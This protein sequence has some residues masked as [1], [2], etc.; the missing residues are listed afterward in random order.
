MPRRPERRAGRSDP[1][2]RGGERGVQRIAGADTLAVLHVDVDG[3]RH[4]V[5]VACS[6]VRLDDDAAYAL[7]HRSVLHGA[8]DLGDD[9][10]AADDA[11][12]TARRRAAD[13][14]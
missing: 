14:R 10:F 11:L 7:D 8:V 1:P 9:R 2:A 13:H 6:F 3:E 4:G 12:R 5:L